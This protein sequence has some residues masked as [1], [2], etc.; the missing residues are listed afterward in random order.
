VQ[1]EASG[2]KNLEQLG[3]LRR[4]LKIEL[5]FRRRSGQVLLQGRIQAVVMTVLYILFFV[6]VSFQVSI[7]AHLK[8][9]CFSAALFLLGLV[10]ILTL[11]KRIKWKV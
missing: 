3:S 11:G 5:N 2:V 10:S 9:I 6:F 4:S 8:L 7:W 1:I